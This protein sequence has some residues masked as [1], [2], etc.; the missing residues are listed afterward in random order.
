VV[1]AP[2][3]DGAL[4]VCARL[5]LTAEHAPCELGYFI[6]GRESEAN[7]LVCRQ[8]ANAAAQIGWENPLE[9]DALLETNDAILSAKGH[10]PGQEDSDE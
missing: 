5:E 3:L 1:R 8:I 7:E 4:N 6:I 9:A 10:V 2:I